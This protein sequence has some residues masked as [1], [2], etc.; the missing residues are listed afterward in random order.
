[1]NGKEPT[2]GFDLESLMGAFV[3]TDPAAIRA[4]DLVDV[5]RDEF[6]KQGEILPPEEKLLVLARVITGYARTSPLQAAVDDL[7]EL[8]VTAFVTACP[9]WWTRDHGDY[10]KVAA[11]LDDALHQ[12]EITQP[13][14]AAMDMLR[15][16][17]IGLM[18][19]KQMPPTHAAQLAMTDWV[20]V[21]Y[22]AGQDDW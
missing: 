2:A 1:V 11:F 6:E 21:L 8:A 5:V 4:A 22:L 17:T 18:R 15:G 3:E 16:L 9:A 10:G 13:T 12:R 19:R 14:S 20:A 7:T